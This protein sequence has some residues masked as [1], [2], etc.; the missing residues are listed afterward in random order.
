MHAVADR[1]VDHSRV[2]AAECVKHPVQYANTESQV[3]R[4]LGENRRGQ[5]IRIAHQDQ[6][7]AAVDQ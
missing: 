4:K 6:G 1:Q 5:L 2:L 7:S 3:V